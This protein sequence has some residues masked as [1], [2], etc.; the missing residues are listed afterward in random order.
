MVWPGLMC[1]PEGQKEPGISVTL[2]CLRHILC[3]G[4][5]ASHQHNGLLWCKQEENLAG[6]KC[7]PHMRF[8]PSFATKSFLAATSICLSRGTKL[9]S[10]PTV[11]N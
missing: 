4:P 11:Q 9:V 3:R 1:K 8:L 6:V 5:R 7:N 10:F 2:K